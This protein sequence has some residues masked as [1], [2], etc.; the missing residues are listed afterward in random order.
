MR[1]RERESEGGRGTG[2]RE[3]EVERET[4][5]VFQSSLSETAHFM[6]ILVSLVVLIKPGR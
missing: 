6:A 3:R 5:C 4:P 1:E 2:V